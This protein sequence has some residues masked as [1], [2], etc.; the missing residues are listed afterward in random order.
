MQYTNPVK[1]QFISRPNRFVAEV[2]LNGEKIKVHVP[3]TGRCKELFIPEAEVILCRSDNP[4]RKM[5]Y[6]LISVYKGGNLVNIDSQNPNRLVL[7]H[8]QSGRLLGFVPS[9]IR[10]EYTYG[11]SRIDLMFADENHGKGLIEVKGCTLETNGLALFPDAPTARGVK[12]IKELT[13]A[14]KEG[15]HTYIVFAVQMQ[16]VRAFSPNAAT[17]PEFAEALREAKKAGVRLLA[18]DSL[19]FPDTVRLN[20]EIKIIL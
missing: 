4:K 20:Q 13:A 5:P 14:Q 7:E 10:R 6:S 17:H 2:L 15:W 16:G 9:Q 1:A 11:N 8:L 18:F 19:V 12:H 3:N